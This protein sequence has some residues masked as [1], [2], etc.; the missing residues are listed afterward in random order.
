MGASIVA[1]PV[2]VTAMVVMVVVRS[3]VRPD[4]PCCR[5]WPHTSAPQD[6]AG[7]FPEAPSGVRGPAVVFDGRS[8][9]VRDLTRYPRVRHRD[10]DPFFLGLFREACLRSVPLSGLRWLRYL[11]GLHPQPVEPPDAVGLLGV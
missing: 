2:V 4:A 7:E 5:Q 3:G 10:G 8:R 6:A 11:A 1:A 9:R